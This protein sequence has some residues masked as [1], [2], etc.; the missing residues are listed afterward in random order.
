MIFKDRK[1]AAVKLSSRLS[2]YKDKEDVIVLAFPRRWVVT[3]FHI[4]NSLNCPLDIIIIRKIGFPGNPELAIG[5]VS[6][7][8]TVV[9]NEDIISSYRISEEYIKSEIKRQQEIISKRKALYRGGKGI[10]TLQGKTIILVD[11]SIATGATMKAAIEAIKNENIARLI[12]AVPVSAPDSAEEIKEMV[13][14]WV[15][16]ETPHFFNAVGSFYEDFSEVSDR[17]VIELL[18]KY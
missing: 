16:L 4:S 11:D 12:I 5:A 3:G 10:P 6:E 13:D 17:E 15:C 1:D 14:E 18:S 2:H 8:G 7:T 9:L